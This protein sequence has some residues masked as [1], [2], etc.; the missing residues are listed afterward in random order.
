MIA[1][2]VGAATWFIRHDSSLNLLEVNQLKKD[3]NKV[4]II[5]TTQQKA[6]LLQVNYFKLDLKL[7]LELTSECEKFGIL[8][9]LC[10]FLQNIF[11]F[12]RIQRK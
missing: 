7:E 6:S 4:T 5:H 2:A 10:A 1:F 9:K 11:D 3:R 8:H 12:C